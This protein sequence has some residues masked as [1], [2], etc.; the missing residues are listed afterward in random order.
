MLNIDDSPD[1]SNSIS[2]KGTKNKRVEK[3]YKYSSLAGR[4][5]AHAS[6]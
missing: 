5:R 2:K 3:L 4:I 1:I 6:V